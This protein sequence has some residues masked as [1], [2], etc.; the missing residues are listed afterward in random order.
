MKNKY[1]VCDKIMF[2]AD[3]KIMHAIDEIHQVQRAE[4]RAGS[5]SDSD[6]NQISIHKWNYLNEMHACNS[7]TNSDGWSLANRHCDRLFASLVLG[8]WYLVL[9]YS[10]FHIRNKF[11]KWAENKGQR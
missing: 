5:D 11:W 9:P 1:F 10:T 4:L 3:N 6:F 8:K 7:L 2:Q